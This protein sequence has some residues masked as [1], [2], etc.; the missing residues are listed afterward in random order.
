MRNRIIVKIIALTAVLTLSFV[1]VQCSPGDQG[2][3]NASVE[4][5]G[6]AGNTAGFPEGWKPCPRCQSNEDRAKDD[7]RYKVEGH[8]FNPRDLSGVW[9]WDGVAQAFRDGKGA[10]AFTPEG[11][12]RFDATI[13]EKAPDGTV[14]HTTDTSG[15]GAGS[16]INCDPYGWPRLYTYHYG[17]E[18]ITLPDRVIQFFELNHTWRTIWTDGRK[19]PE[20]PPM[21]RWMGWAVGRWE[22]DTFVVESNGYDDRSWLSGA[23]PDGGWIHSDQMK[24]I[25]R[26]RRTNYR[27]LESE[28][29]VIDPVIY[30]E[31]WVLPAKG[32]EYLVP[33]AEMGEE[34]CVP[35]DYA[36]FNET[37]FAKA[38]AG[39]K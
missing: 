13:G 24:V 5:E 7:A 10:P 23:N 14:L 29:T 6:E 12:K 2:A 20:E 32:I 27:T 15:R 4:P 11:K 9:G 26:Y 18:F 22:G 30:T 8:P 33:G 3:Q 37:V 28:M 25:E 34:F 19:L 38:A 17:F 16:K 31:P 1:L 39:I 36:D 35:S 21:L